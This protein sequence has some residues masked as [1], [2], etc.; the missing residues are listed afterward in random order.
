[1]LISLRQIERAYRKGTLDVAALRPLDLEI[2]DGEFLAIMGPSGS[3]KST[4]LHILGGLDRPSSGAYRLDGIDLTT[5]D[6]AALSRIRNRNIGFV[7]QSFN[8][9]PQHTVL[10]NIE[11]PLLYAPA[12][13]DADIR[14]R[15]RFAETLAAQVGLAHRLHHRPTE[16]SGGE[17]Q[18]VA[19]A[20]ALIMQP[21]V[22]LAD[23][24]T[25]NLDSR[26]GEEIMRLLRDLHEQGHTVIVVTHEP[27]IAARAQRIL[28]LQD[29]AI[30]R[31]E[32]VSA[33]P[34]AQGARAIP[35]AEQAER[36][37]SPSF[38]ASMLRVA[39]Q[40]ILLHKL[41]SFL[42]VLGIVFGIAAIIAM[43]AIGGGAK[44]ELLEQ[45]S[46]LGTNS[47]TVKAVAPP[48]EAIARGREQLS[49]GVS[50]SD[51]ARLVQSSPSI[52]AIAPARFM[53]FAAQYQ[54]QT[55][56]AELVG[57][58]P[59]YRQTA[60]LALH[61]GR[62]LTQ[63]DVDEQRRVCVIGDDIRQALFAFRQPV[64]EMVKIRMEWFRVVGVLS[65]KPVDPKNRAAAH[66]K[67]V[68]RQA[69][70]PISTAAA[71]SPPEERERLHEI[72]IRVDQA[73]HVDETARL[74]RSVLDRLHHGA[75]DYEL[76]IPRDLLRQSQQTQQVFNVVMGSIA[77]ISLLVGG[78]GIMNIMLATVTERTRE[79]GI[80]RAIGASR[81]MI[82]LQ[83]LIETLT[84]TLVG[85]ALGM[86][87]G[88]G[89]AALITLFAGW[90]TAVSVY[91]VFIACGVSALVGVVFG[92]YPASQA[93]EKPPVAALRYE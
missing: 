49:E 44:R 68:N 8:L 82:L 89:G 22:I 17:M 13:N 32:Q 2:A 93:A 75:Q 19:I 72:S 87:L 58:T 53:A 50:L 9:L 62:F 67:N 26:T 76:V 63:A 71:F 73:E 4:L 88:V 59:A 14:Q 27:R 83:F 66:L 86:L 61:S 21:R 45:I 6:D 77:G 91:T 47:I 52:E 70:I 51:L 41:R 48:E 84:L 18:R 10:Q 16:L 74:L 29:G 56:P 11:A 1:M 5:L 64:G 37:L 3:G 7:F 79:I 35:R 12:A 80:R 20:R 36:R 23:E 85:G 38:V 65:N 15:R 55:A 92:L 24:P 30:E 69:V 31:I 25:G 60:N 46:L 28:H 34:A 81:N 54:Q 78:I 43:L 42:S 39:L 33:A 57:T 90:R 40:G